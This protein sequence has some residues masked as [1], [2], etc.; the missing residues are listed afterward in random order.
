MSGP[1]RVTAAFA[2]LSTLFRTGDFLPQ[3]PFKMDGNSR[4]R[5]GGVQDEEKLR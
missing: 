4:F 2:A 5:M 1:T 3:R